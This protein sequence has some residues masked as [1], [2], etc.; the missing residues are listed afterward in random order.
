M[1]EFKNRRGE[2]NIV[3]CKNTERME[4]ACILIILNTFGCL[5]ECR[6]F[7]IFTDKLEIFSLNIDV[8]EILFHL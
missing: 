3:V 6:F 7:S 5:R 2:I 4:M 1:L 8:R